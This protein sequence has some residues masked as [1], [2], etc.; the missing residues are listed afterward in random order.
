MALRLTAHRFA[1]L[2]GLPI[3]SVDHQ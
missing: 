2:F 1:G 3:D